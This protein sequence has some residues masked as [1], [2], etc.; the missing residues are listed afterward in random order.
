[1][2]TPVGYFQAL[3]NMAGARSGGRPLHQLT[4]S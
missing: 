2:D 3:K 4:A 1:M